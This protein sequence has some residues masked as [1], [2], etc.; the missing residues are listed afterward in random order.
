[1]FF[2]KNV[3]VL[4]IDAKKKE[5]SGNFKNKG[6]EYHKKGCASKVLDHDFPIEELDKAAAPYGIYDIFK[7]EGFVSVGISQDTAEFALQYIRK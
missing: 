3:P 1:M 4:S 6:R 5:N 7:N 2:A